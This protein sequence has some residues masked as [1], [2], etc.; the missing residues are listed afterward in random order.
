MGCSF[1]NLQKVEEIIGCRKFE[2][3]LF[4]FL[5]GSTP[6]VVVANRSGN[7]KVDIIS[8][9]L[10]RQCHCASLG[11]NISLDER[12]FIRS[13]SGAARIAVLNGN[14]VVVS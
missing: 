1:V 5:N 3:S 2:G 12:R 8:A 6:I 14:I 4:G 13:S 7:L 9:V 11:P 10:H